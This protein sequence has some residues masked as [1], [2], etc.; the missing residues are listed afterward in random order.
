VA[1]IATLET[2]DASRR[3][4]AVSLAE[5]PTGFAPGALTGALSAV[6]EGV[7]VMGAGGSVLARHGPARLTIA[8]ESRPFEVSVGT[9]FQV[10]RHLNPVLYADARA[11]AAGVSAGVALDAFGGSGFFAG[12][13]SRGTASA[14][15]KAARLPR[16]R[17]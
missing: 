15:S 8:V 16:G 17:R 10:N 11:E 12:A 2:P 4:A 7:R 3:I 1:E 6:F 13:P 9:F 14:P 5:E